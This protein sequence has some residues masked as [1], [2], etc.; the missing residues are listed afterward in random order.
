M[1]IAVEPRQETGR[2]FAAPAELVDPQSVDRLA[3]QEI[4]F[5]VD[6]I[7]LLLRDRITADGEDVVWFH[8]Q[9]GPQR[10]EVNDD[11]RAE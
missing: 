11:E 4:I 3:H 1:H 7:F 9:V 2:P 5:H 8:E 10:C 6:G